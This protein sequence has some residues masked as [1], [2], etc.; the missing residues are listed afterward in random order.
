MKTKRKDQL[1]ELITREVSAL[2]PKHI[3]SETYKL[4]FI[5]HLELNS[6]SSQVKVWVSAQENVDLLQ[7]ELNFKVRDMQIELNKLLHMK[8]VPKLVLKADEKNPDLERV[9][10][11]LSKL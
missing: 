2:L 6:D 9:E 4:L 11:L 3:R 1:T 8:I 10:N 5:T 7:N